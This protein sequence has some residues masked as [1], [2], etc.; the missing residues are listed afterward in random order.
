[1]R[2]VYTSTGKRP[3]TSFERFASVIPFDQSARYTMLIAGLR[4]TKSYSQ[5]CRK[6]KLS[7]LKMRAFFFKETDIDLRSIAEW[8]YGLSLSAE[9]RFHPRAIDM[10]AKA[11]GI[12]VR[13]G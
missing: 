10:P 7:R 1:M 5:I 2:H 4:S 13:E 11:A 12:P 3:S 6:A 8:A 9:V